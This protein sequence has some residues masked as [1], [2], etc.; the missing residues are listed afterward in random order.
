MTRRTFI[1]LLCAGT[2]G[3]SLRRCQPADQIVSLLARARRLINSN[4]QDLTGDAELR[5]QFTPTWRPRREIDKSPGS[6]IQPF[7][8]TL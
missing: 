6:H 5:E 2:L 3:A 8:Q 1:V 4:T 7:A